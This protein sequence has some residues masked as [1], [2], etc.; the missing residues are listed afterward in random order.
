MLSLSKI[1]HTVVIKEVAAS[2]WWTV[3]LIFLLSSQHLCLGYVLTSDIR[4]PST[5]HRTSIVVSNHRIFTGAYQK[6]KGSR[7]LYSRS[8][9]H[10]TEV[11]EG[12][13]DNNEN[14]DPHS[15]NTFLLPIFPLRKRVRF[16]SDRL[17]LNLYEPRYIAMCDYILQ[18]KYQESPV[19]DDEKDKSMSYIFGAMYTSDKPQ[20]V[21]QSTGPI[22]PVLSKGDVGI[23][24]VVIEH[25][26]MSDIPD[27]DQNDGRRRRKVRLEAVGISRFQIEEIIHDGTNGLS[28]QKSSS[29]K[30]YD[31]NDD[32]STKMPRPFMLVRCSILHDDFA[33]VDDRIDDKDFITSIEHELDE[34]WVGRSRANDML[35]GENVGLPSTKQFIDWVCDLGTKQ[36]KKMG[37]EEMFIRSD[38][39]DRYRAEVLSF[40]ATSTWMNGNRVNNIP[41]TATSPSVLTTILKSTSTKQRLE[42]L[43]T[44]TR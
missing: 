4:P 29:P 19:D 26:E 5:S 40:F 31:D 13:S 1:S 33:C 7:S 30:T 41:T 11:E 14:G 43:Q 20:I 21:P 24:C 28:R 17:T 38:W 22:V 2:P 27:N 18:H 15:T 34:Q 36:F 6:L 32:D 8:A 25:S 9:D 37:N 35:A 23:L 3:C 12:Q 44:T 42:W 39:D 16:P 10:D